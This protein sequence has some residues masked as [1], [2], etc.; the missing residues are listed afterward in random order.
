MADYL[1]R[2]FKQEKPGAELALDTC[3]GLFKTL[4]VQQIGNG[5]METFLVMT[6]M[7]GQM[8]V[9]TTHQKMG[10]LLLYT[11]Q[12]T[13]RRVQQL[14]R[15]GTA[16]GKTKHFRRQILIG[17]CAPKVGLHDVLKGYFCHELFKAVEMHS[18]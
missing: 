17:A 1:S 4:F 12:E 2:V 8:L 3:N 7:E 14:T 18:I 15:H 5:N 16:G 6:Y 10:K 13:F 9:N 11:L